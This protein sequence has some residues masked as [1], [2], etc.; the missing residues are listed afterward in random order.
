M[1]YHFRNTAL[2][3]LRSSHAVR[4]IDPARRCHDR[5]ART[6]ERVVRRGEGR[7]Q[8]G[9][10]E[11][12]DPAVRILNASP[13][14][15]RAD[16]ALSSFVERTAA[17]AVEDHCAE[18]HGENLE[19]APGVPNLVDY[20]WLWGITGFESN[21]VGPVMELQQTILY[22]VRNRDCPP[23]RMSY[24]ACS[25]TRFSEMPAYLEIGL[26]E[27]AIRDLVEYVV[28]LSGREADEDAVAR[29]EENWP[30]CTECHGDD[31]FGYPPYGG[32]ALTDDIWLYGGDRET[33]YDVIANGRLG[34]C[35]PWADE[36]DRATI[37]SLAVHIWN[38]AMGY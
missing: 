31:G 12:A 4:E 27:G 29:A 24:G 25:D 7:A 32:P 2:S 28:A 33:L 3:N 11:D 30:A 15:I 38:Q 14:E 26:S 18:C 35:P 6:R 37:K 17:E 20:E 23:D 21:E 19:G 5:R 13:Y 1:H 36:L 9:A 34:E 22:G 8:R 10:D 16:D